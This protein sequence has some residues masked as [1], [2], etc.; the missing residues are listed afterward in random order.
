MIAIGNF[1]FKYRNLVFPIMLVV[2]VLLTRPGALM[3]DPQSDLIL[4]IAGICVA[5][6]GDL[7]RVGVIG[8]DYIKR[9]G[10]GKEV[11]ADDLVVGGIFAHS[12]NPLYVGNI[13]MIAGLAL[14]YHHPAFYALCL[15]GGVFI[16]LCITAAEENF[17][18]Q[19]FGEQYEEYCRNVPRFLPRL[20]GL[21]QTLRSMTF[22]WRRVL[23]KEYGTMFSLLTWIVLLFL[24]QD[25]H[26]NGFDPESPSVIGIG[27]AWATGL[28]AWAIVRVLKKQKRLGHG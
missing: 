23:R 12:R 13:L 17:L 22:D 7:I 27:A 4:D 20:S 9:G 6:L 8:L 21:G 2:I 3:N 10:K 5:V 18:R 28:I 25:Y 19:K 15:G 26:R 1:F 14:I 24:W 16:Y 11:Y